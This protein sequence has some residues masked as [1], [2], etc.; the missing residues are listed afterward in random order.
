MFQILRVVSDSLI[1]ATSTPLDLNT[2]PFVEKSIPIYWVTNFIFE[3]HI[4]IVINKFES[5]LFFDAK[6]ISNETDF[7][8]EPI[9]QWIKGSSR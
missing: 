5:C 7:N 9:F 8:T 1:N 2:S 6:L 4:R 3:I